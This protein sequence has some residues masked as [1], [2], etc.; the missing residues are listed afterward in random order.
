MPF[1]TSVSVR[2]GKYS[3]VR[4]IGQGAYGQVYYARD[5]LGREVA[6]KEVLPT[7]A[8]FQHFR[9][10]FQKEAQLQAA[11]RHPDI[12]QVY[13]IEEDP[14][15]HELYLVCEY[16]N[17][18][19]LADHLEQH[20]PLSEAE[21][22]TVALDLCAALEAI[23]SKRIVHRDIKPSNILLVKDEHGTIMEAKL[24]DFGVAQ[25][26]KARATTAMPGM[27]YPGTVLYMA[28]EQG[29]VANVLDVRADLYALGLT[30]WEML[31][32]EPYKVLLQH[33]I[34]SLSAYNPV[35]SVGI[36]RVIRHAVEEQ[37]AMRYQSPQV[38]AQELRAVRSSASQPAY[39]GETRM[40]VPRE[41][42]TEHVSRRFIRKPLATISSALGPVGTGMLALFL[43]LMIGA[44]AIARSDLFA[45][46]L[47][48][49]PVK[50]TVASSKNLEELFTARFAA[51]SATNSTV[52][53]RPIQIEGIYEPS[54]ELQ[55]E[56]VAGTL[57]PTV[58]VPSSS[59]WLELLKQE[60][61]EPT[62]GQSKG[63][64]FRTPVT[65]AMWKP[66]AEALGWPEKSIGW[67]DVLSL[68]DNDQGWA[69]YGHPEWGRFTWGHTNPDASSTALS[70]V[71]A[72]FYAAT[73][74][75]EGLTVADVQAA[76]SQQFLRQLAQG[77][78]HYGHTS[79]VFTEH[80]KTYG[81]SYISAVPL[82]ESQVIKFNRSSPQTPLVAIYPREGTFVHDNPFILMAGSTPE[83]QQA[84]DQLY[85]FLVASESQAAIME[86]GY[87]PANPEMKLASPITAQ[88]G[89]DQAQPKTLLDMPG[90]DVVLAAKQAWAANRKRA[91]IVL[92]IDTSHSMDGQKIMEAKAGI[93]FLLTRLL[94]DDRVALVAFSD[95][96]QTLV[97]L[98]LLS[99]NRA[100]LQNAV[101]QITAHGGTAMYDALLAANPVFGAA[102]NHGD[103]IDAVILLSDGA[104]TKSTS[105]L[106]NVQRAYPP[107]G[108]LS[109]FPIAYGEDA[110]KT[111]LQG[112]ADL[113]RTIVIEGT[114]GD[115]SKVFKQISQYF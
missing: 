103:R 8:E 46:L 3:D 86:A 80:M 109:I 24:G 65:I 85:S 62:I 112:I 40:S 59:V 76:E 53:G 15:T 43:V 94:P 61:G 92:V 42:S 17:G 10:K 83:Q 4:S 30:L 55:T 2:S 88:F 44:I 26:Q 9:D 41:R 108:A 16:A 57:R 19:S 82:E 114:S 29:N 99:V 48:R 69:R 73:S 6:V 101:S 71:L 32:G 64:L 77:I 110:K 66:Q 100:A 75:S 97:P 96:P 39:V 84:A 11:F 113:T 87:R 35:A 104:D 37:P 47:A 27:G 90:T 34:P 5:S 78:K 68:I 93:E 31:T 20:G 54:G 89:A 106:A 58:W 21:A 107:E 95:V 52:N 38:M 98:D 81:M 23:S 79:S 111:V 56:L 105:T 25:D 28:P 115:L 36:A 67:S 22:T 12:I 18:G 91:N 102:D 74:K 60:K 33:G 49:P 51:F 63:S 1:I 7:N 70:T 45:S 72:E 13:Y 50:I 14:E